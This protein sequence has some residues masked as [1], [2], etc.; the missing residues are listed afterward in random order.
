MAE[1][2]FFPIEEFVKLLIQLSTGKFGSKRVKRYSSI[3][4]QIEAL[5]RSVKIVKSLALTLHKEMCTLLTCLPTPSSGNHSFQ[6]A[7]WPKFHSFRLEELPH[8]WKV[9][10]GIVP[11]LD[12]ILVQ[13]ATLLY[14][15]II[16]NNV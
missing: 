13:K 14:S 15:T 16:L 8:I 3:R 2:S 6:I 11:G 10:K 1:S 9:A 5:I 7:L 4:K 12:P